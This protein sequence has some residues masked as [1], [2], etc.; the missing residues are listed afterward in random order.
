[1]KSLCAKVGVRYFRFHPLRH[2]GASIMDSVNIPIT[3]IQ[4][5]LGHE[6]RKTTEGYIHTINGRSHGVIKA[7]E[8]ARK[9]PCL[10]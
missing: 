4:E 10:D 9:C 2:S 1:M 7:F 5:I 3:E 6:N 8:K